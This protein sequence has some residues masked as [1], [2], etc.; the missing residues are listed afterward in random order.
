[1]NT[2]AEFSAKQFEKLFD[3]FIREQTDGC[4]LDERLDAKTIKG[5]KCADYFFPSSKIIV[6]LKTLNKDHGDRKFVVDL[7]YSTAKNLGYSTSVVEAWLSSKSSLPKDL[8][9]AVDRK[10]QN[11][12]KGMVRTTNDQIKS[13]R[14]ILRQ[15]HDGILIVANLGENLF[16][17][18]ELLRNIAGHALGRTSLSI[19]AILLITP[20]VAYFFDDTSP[21]HYIAPVYAEDKKYLG[22]FI[23]PLVAKW[24]DFESENLGLE[25]KIE[26]T[27]KWPPS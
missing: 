5:K 15:K 17:P 7:C 1:M 22:D 14:Q 4:R 18:T 11:S 24:I 23:E 26:R 2:E 19:D 21:Q 10:V 3:R 8:E 27:E 16:G 12:L 9:A 13:T 20:G 25:P 6:E